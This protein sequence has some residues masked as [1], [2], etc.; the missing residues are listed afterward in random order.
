MT[1]SVLPGAYFVGIGI[2][3]AL[4]ANVFQFSGLYRYE[5]FEKFG[6]QMG[7]LMIGWTAVSLALLAISFFSKTSAT[8]PESGSASG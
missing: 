8:T 1:A 7:R 4:A 3:I 6:R 2:A 5:E